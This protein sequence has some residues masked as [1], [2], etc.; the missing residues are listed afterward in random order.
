MKDFRMDKPVP[1]MSE[2]QFEPQRESGDPDRQMA[3]K[4]E[5]ERAA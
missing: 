3:T 5:M 2:L 1:Y 4:E